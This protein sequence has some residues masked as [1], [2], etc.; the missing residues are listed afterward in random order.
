MTKKQEQSEQTIIKIIVVATELFA[1]NGYHGTAISDISDATGLTKG[2]LYY[3]FK[4]KEQILIRVAESIAAVWRKYLLNAAS[5]QVDIIGYIDFVF[6][7]FLLMVRENQVSVLALHNLNL[8]IGESNASF[9]SIIDRLFSE[10][11]HDLERILL[12]GQAI[13]QVR[14]DLDAR[15]AAFS[16][17]AMLMGSILSWFQI[18]AGVNYGALIASQK[19]IVLSSIRI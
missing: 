13:G 17:L 15:L 18:R 6:K 7:Q 9:Y 4:D 8:E 19:E 14:S 16:I 1:Q 11:T 12:K 10:F 3:H 5:D 2:A